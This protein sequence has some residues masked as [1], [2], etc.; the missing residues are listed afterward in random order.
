MLLFPTQIGSVLLRVMTNEWNQINCMELSPKINTRE[1]GA[2]TI[3]VLQDWANLA[4]YWLHYDFESD[5]ANSTNNTTALRS[6]M[7]F[8]QKFSARPFSVEWLCVVVFVMLEHVFHS[9]CWCSNFCRLMMNCFSTSPKKPY[10][11]Y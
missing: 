3:E 11:T 9:S 6:Q 5:D 7:I 1:H 8:S 10:D 2:V 4:R